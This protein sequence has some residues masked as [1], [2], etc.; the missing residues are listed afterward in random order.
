MSAHLGTHA[1]APYHVDDDGQT[2]SGW[3]LSTFLG[4]AEV[5]VIPPD[6]ET[7]R[8]AHL[9]ETTAPRL[10]FKT[11]SSQRPPTQWDKQFPAVSLEAVSWMHDHQVCLMG[12]DASS[13]DPA[14][15]TA[16]EAHHALNTAGIVNL[17]NLQLGAVVPGRYTLVAL[18]LRVA[19]GD[20]SPVRA[21]LH[22]NPTIL[23]L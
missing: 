16:L 7:I 6:A 17:E 1:D 19:E 3:T 23:P 11:I 9:D 18:P 2:T 12:T 8:P 21:V 14:E 5:V 20:A 15:S 22:P 4:P 13:V 10:L